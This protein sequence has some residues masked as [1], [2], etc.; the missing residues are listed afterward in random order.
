[1]IYGEAGYYFPKAKLMPFF[2]V[3][4]KD[5]ART[6]TGDETRWSVGLGYMAFGHNVNLKAAY[7]QVDPRVGKSASQFTIQLQ[8][9]YF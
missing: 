2:T 9:F 6:D 3:S 7:G 8:G 5:V 1:M 4:S